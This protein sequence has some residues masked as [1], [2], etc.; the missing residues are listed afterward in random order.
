MQQQPQQP[1]SMGQNI[2]ALVAIAQYVSFI[3]NA[4]LRRPGTWGSRHAGWHM[5]I[6]WLILLSYGPL[7]FPYADARPM[8]WLWE[9]AT[10]MLV[11]HRLAAVL[12]QWMGY[13]RQHSLY[14]GR[15]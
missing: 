13:S 14:G 3:M 1:M 4:L 6:S 9:A 12:W 5:M 10:V 11:V 15:S 8:F 7:F 2:N